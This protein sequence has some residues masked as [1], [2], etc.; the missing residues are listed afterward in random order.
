MFKQL[1]HNIAVKNIDIIVRWIPPHLKEKMQKP[2]FILPS[3]A[4]HNDIDGN[5]WA[6]E[7]ARIAATYAELRIGITTPVI[8]YENLAVRI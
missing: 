4:S 2:V 1:V 8:Y 3:E 7:P 5:D 6:D